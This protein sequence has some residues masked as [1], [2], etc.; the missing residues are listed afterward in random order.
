MYPLPCIE[1]HTK[2]RM[3]C[4]QSGDGD[5]ANSHPRF[6]FFNAVL[7][8]RLKKQEVSP[9]EYSRIHE[10]GSRRLKKSVTIK[11]IP[12]CLMGLG[13]NDLPC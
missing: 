2:K 9:Q 7:S 6:Q 13:Q 11:V 12:R 1:D 8:E 4:F 10:C 3:V 5:P